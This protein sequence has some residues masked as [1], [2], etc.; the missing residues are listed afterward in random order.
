MR[1]LSSDNDFDDDKSNEDDFLSGD[2]VPADKEEAQGEVRSYPLLSARGAGLTVSP[3]PAYGLP[4]AAAAAAAAVAAVPRYG[5]RRD[6]PLLL[7]IIFL[8][9]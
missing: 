3:A 9:W 2:V 5:I 7:Y 1:E 6:L 4:P 8:I